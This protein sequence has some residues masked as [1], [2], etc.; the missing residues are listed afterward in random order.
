MSPSA[1]KRPK[2]ST[3]SKMQDEEPQ[4]KIKQQVSK[5]IKR[6]R[7]RRVF[8]NLSL[9][10]LLKSS[11]RRIKDL[12]KLAKRC[13]NSL[14]RV[15][16]M[17]DITSGQNNVCNKVKQ[18]HE[19]FQETRCP[20]T[21]L[22]SKKLGSLGE[23]KEINPK[24]WKPTVGSRM[25]KAKESPAAVLCNEQVD[26]E[27]PRTSKGLNTRAQRGL[28]TEGPKIIFLKNPHHR[29]PMGDREQPDVAEQWLWFEGLPTRVHTPAPRVMCRSSTLRWIK[30]CCTRF[31]S[32]TLE[33]PMYHPYKFLSKRRRRRRRKYSSLPP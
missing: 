8:K 9:L 27:V 10:K 3:V 32:A 11:N 5:G 4:D 23:A 12:H 1:K 7:L 6:D 19:E 24:E 25:K 15:P 16:K 26:S 13:W 21:D 18:N 29:T 2:K 33:L 28:L 31:C 22:E 17:L 20:K 30:R 14:F